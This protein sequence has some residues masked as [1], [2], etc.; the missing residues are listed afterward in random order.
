MG[1]Y[2]YLLDYFV[3]I[4]FIFFF[5]G[6]GILNLLFNVFL[7]FEE[8]LILLNNNYYFMFFILNF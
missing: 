1:C 3:L 4:K 8:I 5:L 7:E 2:N 6:L